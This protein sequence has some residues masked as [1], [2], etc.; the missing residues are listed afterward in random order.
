MPWIYAIVGLL[1]GC[2]VGIVVARITTPQYK[3]QKTLHK[4][5]DNA[6]YALEQKQQDLVDHFAQ[7]AE[8]L[9]IIGKDYTKL[10][11]HLAKTSKELV[12]NI[13]DHDNPFVKTAAKHNKP[14]ISKSV[15]QNNPAE[16]PEPSTSEDQPPKDYATGATGLL[17]NDELKIIDSKEVVNAQTS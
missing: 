7:T 11:Q 8:L 13:P 17:K 6:K 10:Y 16:E 12:P 5:L 3:S 1:V 14:G 9:D 15:T 2:V 4:E